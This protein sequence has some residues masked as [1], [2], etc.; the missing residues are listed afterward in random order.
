MHPLRGKHPSDGDKTRV[1]LVAVERSVGRPAVRAA[2]A[3]PPAQCARTAST[4]A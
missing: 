3:T 1:L 2:F 4:A